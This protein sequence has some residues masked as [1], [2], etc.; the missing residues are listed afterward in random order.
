MTSTII[1]LKIKIYTLSLNVILTK[2]F[3]VQFISYK[4][5][6]NINYFVFSRLIII[7]FIK[8][9]IFLS[10]YNQKPI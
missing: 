9:F 4:K 8:L 3:N 2:K 1:L 5:Y 6:P 7:N 10:R